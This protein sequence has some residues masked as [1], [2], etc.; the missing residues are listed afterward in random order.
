MISYSKS[1]IIII[2]IS[3]LIFF[4]TLFSA[5]MIADCNENTKLFFS[6]LAIFDFLVSVILWYVLYNEFLAPVPLVLFSLYLF[7]LGYSVLWVQKQSFYMEISSLDV[8]VYAQKYLLLCMNMFFIG[9]VLHKR[10]KGVFDNLADLND[11]KEL[12]SEKSL[13][14]SVILIMIFSIFPYLYNIYRLLINSVTYGYSYIYSVEFN[15]S[16]NSVVSFISN[17]FEPA[18]LGEIVLAKKSKQKRVLIIFVIAI[19]MVKFMIGARAEGV[20]F[21]IALMM[22]FYFENKKIKL[23][24]GLLYLIMGYILLFF[25]A[26][27][28]NIRANVDRSIGDYFVLNISVKDVFN[29]VFKEFGSSITPMLYT[30]KLV[31]D[32][33]PYR[34]GFSYIMSFLSIIP[35]VGIWSVHPSEKYSALAS[36]VTKAANHTWSGLGYSSTAESYINFGWYG[37][38]IFVFWGYI[39]AKIIYDSKNT[40]NN[41]SLK[42]YFISSLFLCLFYCFVR[43][44]FRDMFRALTWRILPILLLY[45]FIYRR[46]L[47]EINESSEAL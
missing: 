19:I 39:I 32:S 35:N 33:Y 22:L 9:C 2:I 47:R 1:Q 30:I 27:T 44:D 46:N 29:E 37:F 45:W 4:I 5:L 6:Y 42:R 25:I 28:K 38:V 41:S 13:K 40:N 31:P 15:S 20:A 17:L 8:V 7:N 24:Q 23:K 21:A 3:I 26:V 11:T 14:I 12:C 36:W 43:S 34:Y 16:S 10:N 18:L